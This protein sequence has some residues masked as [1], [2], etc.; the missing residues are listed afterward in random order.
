M[1][2]NL[3]PLHTKL[4]I[5]RF[6]I[7]EEPDTPSTPLPRQHTRAH[8]GEST[9]EAYKT[10]IKHCYPGLFPKNKNYLRQ[11]DDIIDNMD[12]SI[13]DWFSGI[14]HARKINNNEAFAKEMCNT[15]KANGCKPP[16]KGGYQSRK[17]RR[18]K[19][20]RRTNKSRRTGTKYG[21]FRT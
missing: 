2:G 9:N 12:D 20:Q 1:G 6:S 5:R 4:E 7:D 13:K 14:F 17:T 21:R 18:V 19:S 11:D 16:K 15:L 3:D 8:R 10:F